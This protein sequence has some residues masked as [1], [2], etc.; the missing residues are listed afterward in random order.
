MRLSCGTSI[1]RSAHAALN[2]DGTSHGLPLILEVLTWFRDLRI[3][4]AVSLAA[5]AVARV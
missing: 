4:I 1:F 3:K 2:L 5:A